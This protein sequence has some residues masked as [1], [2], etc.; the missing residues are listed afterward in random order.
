M[1]G[2]NDA[3]NVPPFRQLLITTASLH[4][5]GMHARCCAVLL[6]LLAG[7]LA[8]N[9]HPAR[10][11][12]RANARMPSNPSTTELRGKKFARDAEWARERGMEPGFGGV[13]PGD[14]NAETFKVTIRSKHTN[15]EFSCQVPRDRYIYHV[16][17]ENGI[18]LPIFNKERMCRQG[19]CTICTVK[20]EE[21]NVKLDSALGLLKDMREEGYSLSCCSFPRSDIV[22]ELQREDEMYIKQW[23]EGFEG[24]GVE[25]GGFLPDED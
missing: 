22:C 18:D 25:W 17:E 13:W 19:C 4:P 9:P 10:A 24:G 20:V 23:S 7:I 12:A 2:W 1:T 6:S 8:F 3:K 5:E 14:P 21:G 15:E 16:F 11:H